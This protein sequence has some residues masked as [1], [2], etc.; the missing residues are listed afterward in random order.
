MAEQRGADELPAAELLAQLVRDH[1]ILKNRV[2]RIDRAVKKLTTDAS[3]YR[4][5][6]EERTTLTNLVV[7]RGMAAAERQIFHR[8][9]VKLL[10]AWSIT[11]SALMALAAG[12][13]IYHY[14][15]L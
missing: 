8:W 14:L 1:R 7:S 11:S 9:R 12:A 10:V 3:N 6:D 15:H 5:T 13:A 4:M 2:A